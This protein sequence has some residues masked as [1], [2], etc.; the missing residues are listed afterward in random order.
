MNISYEE[1][2]ELLRKATLFDTVIYRRKNNGRWY[3]VYRSSYVFGFG[4]CR[5]YRR[6]QA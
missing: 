3:G 4:N 2:A 1:L 6:K 5:K